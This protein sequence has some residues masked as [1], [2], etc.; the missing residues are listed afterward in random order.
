VFVPTRE[1]HGLLTLPR[2]LGAGRAGSWGGKR[3]DEQADTTVLEAW[4]YGLHEPIPTAIG[5]DQSGLVYGSWSHNQ[6][7]IYYKKQTLTPKEINL[8]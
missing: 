6:Q 1:A 8:C 3:S 2:P 7:A 5:Y 4:S